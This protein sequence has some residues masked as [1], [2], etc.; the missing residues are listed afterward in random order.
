MMTHMRIVA[1]IV[2]YN[3]ATY[4]EK[5]L[6]QVLKQGFDKV[7]VLDDASTD[8]SA[9]IYR[10]F[11]GIEVVRSKKH[12]GPIVNRNQMLSQDGGDVILFLDA[13]MSLLTSRLAQIISQ[14]FDQHKDMGILGG[15]V[16][17]QNGRPVIFNYG[18]DI[19]PLMGAFKDKLSG[20]KAKAEHYS[21]SLQK[22]AWTL[23][24]VL[25]VRTD[26]FYR[27]KG[28]DTKFYRYHEGPDLCKR[29]RRQGYDTYLTTNIVTQHLRPFNHGSGAGRKQFLTASLMWYK[30]HGFRSYKV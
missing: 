18:R 5:L 17:D 1:A 13:D 25:A 20:N 7:Y 3:D 12:A 15:Q 30:K 27:L 4:T 29:A 21:Q 11:P 26:L 6:P 23:E 2:N 16:T 22:V 8:H 28:F 9:E 10:E 19:D 14:L 24:G